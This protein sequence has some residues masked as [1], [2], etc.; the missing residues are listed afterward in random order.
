MNLLRILILTLPWFV[1]GSALATEPVGWPSYG[2]GNGAIHHSPLSDVRADNVSK[3]EVAWVHHTGDVA[4]GKPETPDRTAYEVT[5]ILADGLLFFCSPFNRVFAVDPE[6]GQERWVYDPEID[7]T[8]A[9]LNQAVC[10]GVATWLD[11]RASATAPCRRRIFTG[12]ND[13]RLI[14]LDAATGAPCDDFGE[15][16]EVDL[17]R[18]VGEAAPGEYQVTSPPAI[19]GDRVIV[20]AAIG[21]NRRVDA[22]SGVLRAFDART[23]ELVWAWNPLPADHE[24]LRAPLPPGTDY[25]LGTANVW[26]PMVVD[27][28]RDLLFAPTG[29]ASPDYYGGRRKGSDH[30]ASSVVALRG[31]TGEVVWHFQTVHHDLWDYDVSSQPTLIDLR[32]DGEVVPALVQATKMG[33]VFILHRETGI[34]LFPVEERPVPQDGV[35]G[36]TLSATQPFPVKPPPLVP[37]SVSED[38]AWGL[39][40]WDKGRCRSRI[41]ALR[42]DGIFTPPS[43]RGSL[44]VPGAIG[45]SNWG[46]VAFD[47]DRNILIANVTHMPFVATLFPAEEY[48]RRS[49]AEPDDEIRPQRGTPYGLH[50]EKLVSGLG[51]PC[52]KPPWG[53]LVAVSLETG[54]ILWK[55]PHGSLRDILPVPIPW[56]V[57]TPTL[58]GSLITASGLV[59]IGA[60][61]DNYIRAYDI[62]TGKELWKGRLEAAGIATPMTYRVRPGGKQYIVI[63]AGG[64]SRG[65]MPLGDTLVAFTLPD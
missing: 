23:G 28:R 58:G 24:R 8:V 52:V 38:D 47:P 29:N 9:Y 30:F 6:S 16:G 26:A 5:P 57:G 19:I 17:T 12:T 46:G 21:D 54:E 44:V 2:G 61:M 62:T 53:T 22:P 51:I 40:F 43:L 50:R 14:A 32:R 11:D 18:G 27:A 35:P 64:H 36:E 37:S 3:L 60:A 59:F 49:A 63:A 31:S 15:R 13:A 4:D 7:R 55:V 25:P 1:S 56:N 33:H 20:G 41:R 10:R 48:E 45:G 34:P 65:G 42:N 39:T